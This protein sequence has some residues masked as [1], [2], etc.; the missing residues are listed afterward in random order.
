MNADTHPVIVNLDRDSGTISQDDVERTYL[1]QSGSE[2]V[3]VTV[4]AGQNVVRIP[5]IA[6]S[7]I[8]LPF[9]DDDLSARFS[10]DNGNVA[11][12]SGD[13]TIILQGYAD[14]VENG[15]VNVVDTSGDPVDVAAT[16]ATTDPNLDIQTAAGPGAGDPGTGVD[17]NGGVFTP[18]DPSAGIG[19]LNAIGGLGATALSYGLIQVENRVLIPEDAPETAAATTPENLVPIN[20]NDANTG[21][22]STYRDTNIMIVLDTSFTMNEDADQTLPGVQKR[23]DVAK[24]VLANLLLTYEALG[25]VAVTIVTFNTG[26]SQ[27]FSWG[28]VADAI[29]ALNAPALIAEGLTNYAAALDTAADAWGASGKLPGD[30]NNVVYFLSDG[31]PQERGPDGHVHNVHLTDAQKDAWDSFLEHPANGIDHVYA[32]GI[33]D[34]V[35][36]S[37]PDLI[38]VARPDGDSLPPG[39]VI[40]VTDPAA[41]LSS[42]LVSTIEVH[43]VSGNVLTGVDTSGVGDNGVPGQ[44]DVG[45]DGTTH[46][47]V[48]SYVG[49]NP[50]YTIE[51]KWDGS[52][53][54][55][56]YTG[57]QNVTVNNH[58][59]SF[60]TEYGKMTFDFETGDYTFAATEVKADTDVVFHYETKD[61]DGDVDLIGGT[62]A[63]N[64]NSKPGGAD[65][66][67]TIVDTPVPSLAAVDESHASAMAHI[68]TTANDHELALLLAS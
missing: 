27:Y 2:T 43:P 18:F 13:T 58:E 68:P 67:I 35:S 42:V 41:D 59:V 7:T 53:A 21:E 14:A 4:P 37:D 40:S 63:D 56:T 32:V 64:S 34:D 17:N 65:L 51:V 6:G 26:A 1:T 36:A 12:K 29:A 30:T 15:G 28:S 25:D 10:D 44:A 8:R 39:D 33:G 49:A 46:I 22:E 11:I 16:V 20:Y 57:G 45:G 60:D 31:L 9:E 50:A 62:D 47:D 3:D 55:A 61:A 54:A 23:I 19:G 66:V 5:V 52:A 24:E 48:L 38:S